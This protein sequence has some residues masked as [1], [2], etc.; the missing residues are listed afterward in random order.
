MN[1]ARPNLGIPIGISLKNSG[2]AGNSELSSRPTPRLSGLRLRDGE[3]RMKNISRRI[4]LSVDMFVEDD[5]SFASNE[6]VREQK[7]NFAILS[8]QGIAQGIMNFEVRMGGEIRIEFTVTAS[9]IDDHGNVVIDG[10]VKL[11]EGASESTDDLDG[12]RQ[13]QL[14]CPAG[15][16]INH[17]VRVSNDDEGGDYATLRLALTNVRA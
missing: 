4:T 16:A 5:E 8:T 9:L 6:T 10:S 11:F 12:S 3:I 2:L 15:A 13:F 14:Y 7:T 17:F 1:Q